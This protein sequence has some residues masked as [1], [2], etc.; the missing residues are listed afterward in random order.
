M[1]PP[2]VPVRT[3][4][5][6]RVP[7]NLSL[8]LDESTS[9]IPETPPSSPGQ[10]NRDPL[11][12][13][14]ARDARNR[15]KGIRGEENPTIAV[16]DTLFVKH[17]D[18]L[19]RALENRISNVEKD[20]KKQLERL[21]DVSRHLKKN[22]D[23]LSAMA[24]YVG[25]QNPIKKVQTLRPQTAAQ[26]STLKN[27]LNE[28]VL[29]KSGCHIVAKYSLAYV[30]KDEMTFATAMEILELMLFAPPAASRRV[31]RQSK[32]G[33]AFQDLR[34]SLMY[35]YVHNC[36]LQAERSKENVREAVEYIA[37]A[38]AQDGATVPLQNQIKA[39]ETAIEPAIWTEKGFIGKQ[40]VQNACDLMMGLVPRFATVC[41]HANSTGGDEGA[42]RKKRKTKDSARSLEEEIKQEIIQA[43]WREQTH[44]FNTSRQ[45]ARR[46]MT[47]CVGFLFDE[48]SKSYWQYSVP[49]AYFGK[50][51]DIG[52][53]RVYK[54]DSFVQSHSVDEHNAQLLSNVISKFPDLRLSCSYQ[55]S[56]HSQ[57]PETTIDDHVDS[58]ARIEREL[59]LF[60]MALKFAT[61]YFQVESHREL[62]R[63][64][65]E[66]LKLVYMVAMAFGAMFE[67]ASKTMQASNS[68]PELLIQ[69]YPR[70]VLVES[71]SKRAKYV[72]K[73]ALYISKRQYDILTGALCV[74]QV[75][76]GSGA[77]EQDG[78]LE[79]SVTQADI[80]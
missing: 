35:N 19:E 37:I 70:F 72:Q 60:D 24:L 39:Y 59:C 53:T 26:L 25:S 30:K 65:P 44:W 23:M 40:D 66:S 12:N 51:D 21:D 8:E 79:A 4:P 27:Y 54:G 17:Y 50:V 15:A 73:Y 48:S 6:R 42:R 43:M 22:E 14:S 5:S 1:S 74:G 18:R 32:H 49:R 11:N 69:R 58:T 31:K 9:Y 52:L 29:S 55:V 64:V 28:D 7:T 68:L 10:E 63:Y 45:E 38:Q 3:L 34:Y 56:I 20:M 46:F 76:D 41:N 16:L 67:E 77:E 80:L 2:Y 36:R 13:Q 57:G 71:A 61:Y 47:K 75:Q 78:L 62:M 33:K